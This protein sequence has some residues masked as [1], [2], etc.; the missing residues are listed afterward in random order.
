MAS[1]RRPAA[2][3]SSARS[4]TRG[5]RASAARTTSGRSTVTLT[6]RASHGWPAVARGRSRRRAARVPAVSGRPGRLLARRDGAPPATGP[7][8]IG[9][10]YQGDDLGP[11]A[12]AVR[13]EAA[14]FDSVWCGDHVGHLLDGIATL[15][16]Y[17]GA[18][19]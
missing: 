13:A 4:A 1:G 5:A 8:K 16:C 6:G 11:K 7:M 14:G 12:F 9:V 18:T 19:D 2:S 17:A 3:T 15:G 10:Q